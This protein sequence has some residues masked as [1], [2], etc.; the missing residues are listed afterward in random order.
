MSHHVA[1]VPL[2]FQW[3]TKGSGDSVRHERDMVATVPGLGQEKTRRREPPA[4][5][6][7]GATQIR[8]TSSSGLI[9]APDAR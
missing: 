8:R 3:V 6:I 2:L 1:T 5:L 9:D 7:V 4:G